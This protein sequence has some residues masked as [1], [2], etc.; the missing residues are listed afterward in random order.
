MIPHRAVM[1]PGPARYALSTVEMKLLSDGG[2]G[3]A[4]VSARSL[5]RQIRALGPRQRPAFRRS[6]GPDTLPSIVSEY[7]ELTGGAYAK[8][9]ASVSRAEA[10]Q[11]QTIACDEAFAWAVAHLQRAFAAP[12]LEL[13]AR[14]TATALTHLFAFEHAV[15]VW[16]HHPAFRAIMR[17]LSDGASFHHTM[18]QLVAAAQFYSHGN[19]VGLAHAGSGRE[20]SADLFLRFTTTETLHIE[21]KAPS[22]LTYPAPAPVD[23]VALDACVRGTLKKVRGQI[24][25]K[26]RGILVI[27]GGVVP[28]EVG[29]R[30]VGA[31]EAALRAKG[32]DHA[33]L[34]GVVVVTVEPSATLHAGAGEPRVRYDVA[35]HHAPVLNPHFAGQNPLDVRPMPVLGAG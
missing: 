34:A 8:Q 4:F 5:E 18:T 26:K 28:T 2:T 25:S 3:N 35:Y 15:E 7:D 24:S 19:R 14:D 20:R 21:V 11:S 6:I 9:A 1:C 12:I 29:D 30:L 13:R 17:T 16:G 10:Q 27:A 33:G 22:A 23:R 32:R 31:V